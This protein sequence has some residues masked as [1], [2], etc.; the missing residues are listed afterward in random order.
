M[1]FRYVDFDLS[2][3]LEAGAFNRST[4]AQGVVG[5]GCVEIRPPTWGE[6][7]DYEQFAPANCF[8]SSVEVYLNGALNLYIRNRNGDSPRGVILVRPI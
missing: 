8:I 6:R 2:A 3:T 1:A 4:L 5:V 7:R